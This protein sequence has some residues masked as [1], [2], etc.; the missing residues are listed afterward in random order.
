M[1][2]WAK[3]TDQVIDHGFGESR[4]GSG[5]NGVVIHHAGGTDALDYV[6]NANA[7]S[8]HPTYHIDQAGKKTGIVH[9]NRR[10][11]STAHSID[12]EAVT[13]ELNNESTGGEWPITA[14]TMEAL[15]QVI[16]D[17]E[18]QSRR[19][20]FVKN[21]PGKEQTGFF[22][23]WHSQYSQTACPG[24]YITKRIDWIVNE[25][26]RRKAGTPSKPVVTSPA[27]SRPASSVSAATSKPLPVQPGNK[28]EKA[29]GGESGAPY[30]PRGPLMERLQRALAR[31]K[32]Y[33]GKIDGIG[34]VLTAKG[35]QETLNISGRNGGVQV[36]DGS[37]PTLVDGKLGRNNAW[38]I[39]EYAR[40]FGSYKG[41]QDGDPREGSWAGFALGLE[42]P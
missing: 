40:D 1:T 26:N 30:W 6:A 16:A 15:L 39:Q 5:I 7:R 3:T 17:H 22:I 42:R 2:D 36:S 34:G 28:W 8:S 38:G 37:R 32:R 11:Y 20:G 19:K 35:V 9:P 41:L 29:P 33:S 21:V 31:K 13:F 25:L 27:P 18:R 4:H 23:A 24:P 10:P 12:Q 14:A